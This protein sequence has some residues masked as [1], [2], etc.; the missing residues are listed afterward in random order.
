MIQGR[1]SWLLP[2]CTAWALLAVAQASGQT[3]AAGTSAKALA[4]LA[5]A[6]AATGGTAWDRITGWHERGRHGGSAYDTLL[7]FRR[8]GARFANTR[9]GATHV[10]GF[11]GTVVWVLGPD[12]KVSTSRDPARLADMRQSA[13][14]STFA[15]FLPAR[16]PAQFDYLGVQTDDGASFDVVKVSPLG[17]APIA[18]WVER[19]THVPAR[20]VDRSPPKPMVGRLSDYRTVGGVREPF[21]IDLSDGD[22]AHSQTVEVDS[23]VLQPVGSGAFD[24]PT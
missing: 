8:Y 17:A 9:D 23:V 6:K 21:R 5:S 7:D 22:P 12:G 16:F 24:P 2:L 19:S 14:F 20:F 11:N 1:K 4:V 3:H 15:F 18:V 10:R 13:Y